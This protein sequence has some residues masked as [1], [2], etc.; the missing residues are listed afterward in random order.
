MKPQRGQ[1]RKEL[2]ILMIS[3]CGWAGGQRGHD[4]KSLCLHPVVLGPDRADSSAAK[5]NSYWKLRKLT[6]P[7][8]RSTHR[9]PV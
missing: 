5:E 2:S 3:G 9:L 6:Q 7:L 4:L 8:Q 1:L